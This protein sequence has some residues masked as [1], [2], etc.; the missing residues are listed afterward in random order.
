M[1]GLRDGD[2]QLPS[3]RSP[4]KS[5]GKAS[6]EESSNEGDAQKKSSFFT[7]I[8]EK[9][10]LNVGMLITMFKGALPPTMA[11]ALY[12]DTG[13]ADTYSTI[14]YLVAIMSILSFAIM[15]RA[16]FVQTMLFNIVGICIGSCIA[17]LAIYCSVQARA[18]TT[19]H[20][21]PT[22]GGPSPGA[23]VAPYNSS[24][25]AVCAIWLFSNI[26]VS[27]TLRASRPQL[28]F[29]VIMY[30]IF[31]NVASTYAPQFA[32]MAQGIAFVE[33]LMEGFLTGFGIATAISFLF[34]PL[35]SRTVVFKTAAA[36]IGALRGA[37][38]AQ[39]GYLE[40]LESKEAFD[41]TAK[42]E[43]AAS[44]EKA[45]HHIL[46]HK[47]KD[48]PSQPSVEARTLKAAVAALAELAGKINGDLPFAKRELAYGKLDASEL[49]ELVKLLR[50]VMLPI[51]GMSS[52]ADIFDRIAKRRGWKETSKDDSDESEG[53]REWKEEEIYQWTEIMRTLHEPFQVLTEAMDQG[54]EHALYAL[55][56][57]KR[58]K[59]S[60]NQKP[61]L[62]VNGASPDVEAKG[63]TIEPGDKD[64]AHFLSTKIDR[65][66]EQRR[67][68]LDT[69]C[70]QH[71]LDI[72]R[73][74]YTHEA[75]D[76]TLGGGPF[77]AAHERQQRRLYLILYMEFLLWSTGQAILDLVRFAD[78][79]VESGIMTKKR[80]T[81]PGMKRI[82]KWLACAL[83]H[84]DSSVDHTPDSTETAG[85]NIKVGDAYQ[86]SR[87]PEHLPPTNA[88]QRFGNGI[89]AISRILGSQESAFGF[90]VACATLSIAIVAYLKDTQ[91]FFIQQ[92]LVW[93][94]IMVAIGM[95]VTAGAGVFGFIGRVTG[96]TIGMC[97]SYLVWYIVDGKTPGVIVLL[98]VFT[99][100]EIYFVLKYPRFIVIAMLT[101]VTQ[102]LVVGYELQ[103][104]KVGLKIAE[105]N[106]QPAY[107]L[108]ELA[109][110]RLACV[111]GGILVA[112]IWTFFPYP[113]TA[114]SQLRKDLGASLYLLANY[115]SCVHTTI[116]M[117]LNGTEG[118]P[119]DKQSAGRRLDKAREKIFTKEM[120]LLAGLRQHSAFTAW[121]PTF[122]GK[123]PRKQYNTII[124][125]AEKKDEDDLDKASWLKDFSRLRQNI[126]VTSRELTSLLSLLSA[127]VINGT[128]LPPHL[129]A[130]KPYRLSAKL[131][132]I[133]ADI[134][135]ISHIAEPGY[136]AFAV[137]QIAS[138]LISDDMGE[139]IS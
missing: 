107:P 28:Q 17:L 125:E 116:G 32:T 76:P 131:E 135:S 19:R 47:K 133:D 91:A 73:N 134:L 97:T 66:Y 128:A 71:G 98:F 1:A 12:Q 69:W 52:I 110:Y 94:M 68:S 115:Y 39:S 13:F 90:R 121:E 81:A 9:S 106:G 72:K 105:S 104:R 58:P 40:S 112:F 3:S 57:T 30:S 60:T 49:S 26:Y 2:E 46:C 127:S 43:K 95:T 108:Y 88:W 74:R 27:N 83:S 86:R 87:D 50:H 41:G 42:V 29:P 138:S 22:S 79:K 7:R 31:A 36:Y 61:R 89:R 137:M 14:G 53:V 100:I 23:A 130:P 18:H 126:N 35:T 85:I 62:R 77:S 99:F 118:D 54:L 37:L 114:R 75:K 92:R 34:F 84:E 6:G 119:D 51:M 129:E 117:R 11:I 4:S 123:F 102:V 139:L 8:W 48:A 15:P 122:G 16:K 44:D 70:F 103:V 45:K 24:A 25:S 10:G 82:R 80:V 64:F 101:M 59:R 113:L 132:A 120:A 67:V 78:D 55:D 93:A 65:F 21:E 63:E 96:T 56:L 111:A 33:R 5:A 124:N 109:P 20:T 38:K 136:A